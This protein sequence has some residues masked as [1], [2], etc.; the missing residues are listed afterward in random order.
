MKKKIIILS[1]IL[2]IITLII[3]ITFIFINRNTSEIKKQ[4]NTSST[5]DK[6]KESESKNDSSSTIDKENR[7]EDSSL[8]VDSSN[9]VEEEK[10]EDKTN[11]KEEQTNKSTSNKSTSKTETNKQST[12]N[13]N[14]EEN[15]NDNQNSNTNT[16]PSNPPK[17]TDDEIWND[18]ITDPETIRLLGGYV[19][20]YNKKQAESKTYEISALGYDARYVESCTEISTGLKCAYGIIANVPKNTCEE[21]PLLDFKW[22]IYDN[23]DVITYMKSIGYSCDG[24]SW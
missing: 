9:K 23:I 4:D 22:W 19:T 16:T 5:I 24:L 7:E 21:N 13:Q 14:Q 10:I 3:V 15:K 17:K 6:E 20:K 8:N 1:S 11:I 12:N 2:I 18:F